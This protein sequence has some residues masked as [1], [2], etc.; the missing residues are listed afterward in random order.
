MNLPAEVNDKHN[1]MSKTRLVRSLS[2][3]VFTGVETTNG[4]LDWL[5][6]YMI[7]YPA[8][9]KRV[10]IVIDEEISRSRRFESTNR[11]KLNYTWTTIL[12]VMR[13]K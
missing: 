8:I 9:Q 12:E 13:F 2:D 11:P 1:F 7:A 5:I 10:Q 4:T 3:I 6:L